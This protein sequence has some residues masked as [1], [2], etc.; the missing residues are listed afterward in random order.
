[1]NSH[2]S[3][4]CTDIT[5][6]G[7]V[8]RPEL[9]FGKQ[10]IRKRLL[11]TN[12]GL[13]PHTHISDLRFPDKTWN[14]L[15]NPQSDKMKKGITFENHKT[16]NNLPVTSRYCKCLLA[17]LQVLNFRR[18][19]SQLSQGNEKLPEKPRLL[20]QLFFQTPFNGRGLHLQIFSNSYLARQIRKAAKTF[21][22]SCSSVNFHFSRC[23]PTRK[24]TCYIF[25]LNQI[26]KFL[27]KRSVLESLFFRVFPTNPVT[28][29]SAAPIW[30]RVIF[31]HKPSLS[32]DC[33]TTLTTRNRF[34]R[35]N[36]IS[37]VSAIK[38]KIKD[39]RRALGVEHFHH[40]L[41]K[42]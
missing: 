34:Q 10:W 41:D 33:T 11:S 5:L 15:T 9:L 17:K 8:D 14:F 37:K 12:N 2:E 1:M 3:T 24:V 20:Q 40:F 28:F 42:R 36:R 30:R 21:P 13:A 26:N 19:F 25:R 16:A 29:P 4:V 7:R 23:S 27:L 38:N 22:G 6:Q 32:T 18:E 31:E 39:P 35:H